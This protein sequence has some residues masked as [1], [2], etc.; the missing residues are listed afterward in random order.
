MNLDYAC[1]MNMSY[2][3]TLVTGHSLSVGHKFHIP[4]WRVETNRSIDYSIVYCTQ[5]RAESKVYAIKR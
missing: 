1:V 3:S 4:V 2:W 5:E